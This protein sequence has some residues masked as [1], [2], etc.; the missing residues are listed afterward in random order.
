M[1]DILVRHGS[2]VSP[3]ST[4]PADLAIKD[5]KI[6]AVGAWGSLGGAKTEVDAEGKLVMPGLVDPHVH[7]SHPFRDG[8]SMDD[9]YS[10]TVAAAYGGTTTVIDFAIQW[11]RSLALRDCIDLRR[12][13]A[14][15]RV[16]ID[17]A[18]HACPT[19]STEETLTEVPELIRSGVPSFKIYMIYRKQGRMVDDAILLGM[20]AEVKKQGGIVG[21]HAE[22]SAIAE[23]NEEIYL[24]RGLTG[25]ENFPLIKPNL[26]EAECVNRALYLN[27]WAGGRLYIFHLSTQEGLEMV[28]AARS[29]NK[30]VIA[31]TCPH[32]LTLTKDIYQRR[33]GAN[34]ICSPPLRSQAD[35][36]ALWEGVLDGTISAI[37]SDHCGFGKK[38][39]AS[40]EGDFSRTPHG[41]PGIET[42]LPIIYTEGVLKGRITVNQMVKVL[43]TNPAKIFG[44][45]PRK[46]SFLPGSD[47][48]IVVFDVSR[49]R[50]LQVKELHGT[51]DWT[52]YE[53][54]KVRGSVCTTICRGEVVIKDGQYC[55]QK[56][57]GRFLER[58]LG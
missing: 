15:G 26:V 17:Y 40:G 21:V 32:Y 34:F 43:S 3:D 22:N 2:L 6:L 41:L 1:I 16:V 28:R 5:G 50:V 13:Q 38:Q 4:I 42:R 11:D 49:D 54:M 10:A 27:L 51:V 36:D 52:P 24:R 7:I 56:G 37:G 57:H 31:E 30:W 18:L 33:D 29:K 55:G 48:D 12:S 25:P 23:F 46:G 20:L 47:A 9:F 39:K 44:L 8:V 58:K 45:Y 35:I 14:D 19:K 53:G